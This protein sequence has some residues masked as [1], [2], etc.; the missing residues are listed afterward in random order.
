M[1]HY[2][3]GGLAPTAL[4][5]QQ[6]IHLHSEVVAIAIGVNLSYGSS[7]LTHNM[8]IKGSLAKV[9]IECHLLV[10]QPP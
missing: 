9:S 4:F 2:L 1:I 8:I 10:Y 6:T 3:P 7:G 5:A